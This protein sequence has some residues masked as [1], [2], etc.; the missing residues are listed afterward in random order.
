MELDRA[1]ALEHW[2]AVL[3]TLNQGIFVINREGEVVFANPA[4]AN[5][6][7][8][9][10]FHLKD[11]A[12][13]RVPTCVTGEDE[14]PLQ[15]EEY[16]AIVAIRS[17]CRVNDFILG[18]FNPTLKQ[19][20]WFSVDA[21]PIYSSGEQEPSLAYAVVTDITE[22]RNA[23]RELRKSKLNLALAQRIASIGSAAACFRTGEWDW[24]DETFRIYGVTR[25]NFVPSA[26]GLRSLVHPDDWPSLYANIPRARKGI[27]PTPVE[28]YRIKRPDGAERILRRIATAVKDD[29][30]KIIGIVATV[31]DVT[32]LRIAQRQNEILQ[33]Q[34]YHAQ[35]LD[36][37]GTL[38]GGI[39]HDLNNTLVPVLALSDAILQS[40]EMHDANRPLIE[41]IRQ[42][43]QRASDLV[44]QILTFARREVLEYESF[45]VR[46]FLRKFAPLIRAIVPSSIKIVE[47]LPA[48]AQV[49]G[50]QGQLHQVI[51]NLFSNAAHAIGD[52]PGYIYLSTA[53]VSSV[54]PNGDTE[55]RFIQISVSD[56]GCGMSESEQA[57]IFE[58]FF[59]T[60]NVGRGLGLG[61]SVAHGIVASHGGHIYV[62]S[63]LNEGTRMDVVLPVANS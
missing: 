32:E 59:T 3:S 25:E 21:C 38:A 12:A 62:K 18:T 1:I 39:A 28:E 43:G 56:T 58:P 34:L 19:R 35:R 37:L 42:G 63:A 48:T 11:I 45:D 30:G 33:T 46:T 26:E 2:I 40:V 29:A 52:R 41:L 55:K 49:H 57:R 13:E 23:E 60:K 47:N 17:K 31:Q 44:A 51:L 54:S 8:R 7:G 22:Q 20:R 10:V 61:L 6:L 9:R 36:S 14:K 4:V 15:P 16:P 27:E 53:D 50:N 24:S 5:L